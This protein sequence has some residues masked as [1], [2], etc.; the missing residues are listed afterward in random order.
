LTDLFEP[1]DQ[2]FAKLSSHPMAEAAPYAEVALAMMR[3]KGTF[4]FL[5]DFLD[6][7]L[8]WQDPTQRARCSRM[9]ELFRVWGRRRPLLVARVNHWYEVR[10]PQSL[11]VGQQM[12][13][14]LG[15]RL[16]QPPRCSP[17]RTVELYPEPRKDAVRRLH[18]QQQWEANLV[19]GLRSTCRGFLAVRGETPIVQLARDL[20][21]MWS[22]FVE[23]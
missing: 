10:P 8:A 7:A 18:A 2:H 4:L 20:R 12:R 11:G 13:H 23:R 16:D 21:L 17:G 6:A 3:R 1:I 5:G 15:D 22:R 14:P 19:P 9:L